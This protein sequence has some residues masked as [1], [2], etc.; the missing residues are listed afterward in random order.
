MCSRCSATL[1]Q[2]HFLCNGI[3]LASHFRR[4]VR[5]LCP[6][7]VCQEHFRRNGS[8][9]ASHFRRTACVFCRWKR[10]SDERFKFCASR[11]LHWPLNRPMSSAMATYDFPSNGLHFYLDCT[12]C[13]L[14]WKCDGIDTFSNTFQRV[15]D[16]RSFWE[17]CNTYLELIATIANRDALCNQQPHA[18][19][20][21]EEARRG[22]DKLSGPQ[23]PWPGTTRH[24]SYGSP[25]H[26]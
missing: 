6:A 9:F 3:G 24:T 11:P 16:R 5:V 18:I 26:C 12:P 7:T 13:M 8:R 25:R 19:Y 14:G 10:I 21:Y 2:K 22:S 23:F 15:S 17:F 20:T 1:F 4:T